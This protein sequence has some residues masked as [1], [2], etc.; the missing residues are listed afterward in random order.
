[1]GTSAGLGR[2]VGLLMLDSALRQARVAF[3]HSRYAEVQPSSFVGL[4]WDRALTSAVRSLADGLGRLGMAW[5]GLG[6]AV[7]GVCRFRARGL[8]GNG[9]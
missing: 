5:D 3:A 8:M 6:C 9:R 2:G 4:K 7:S 1:M